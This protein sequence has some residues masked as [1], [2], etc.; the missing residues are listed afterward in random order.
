MT[1]ESK[2][3]NVVAPA[4]F[5]DLL[6]LCRACGATAIKDGIC[7]KCGHTAKLSDFGYTIQKI[8][9]KSFI[10]LKEDSAE[11]ILTFSN[12]TSERQKR[13]I[14]VATNAPLSAVEKSLAMLAVAG[15]EEPET[16]T[17]T[18]MEEQP[19]PFNE[20]TQ[21]KARE[22][23]RDPAFFF[24]LGR[25]FER[26]FIIPKV[27]KPRFILGEER[28]KRLLGPLMIGAAK[29]GMTS[30]IR[31]IGDPGTAK[32]TMVRMWLEIMPIK[33]L[34]RSYLT[35]AAVRYSSNVKDADLLYIPD[36]PE[37]HGE[38]ARQLLFM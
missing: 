10:L 29:L 30:L 16:P 15:A 36:T 9:K 3:E 24:K 22:L 31:V 25:V 17:P 5:R 37:M 32:D 38:S 34:E 13:S 28:N 33:Y 1:E 6:T 35:A 19:S 12:L 4:G 20:E 27:N 23:L 8:S 2:T 18:Q 21:Q 26:G 11:P 7:L 14:M